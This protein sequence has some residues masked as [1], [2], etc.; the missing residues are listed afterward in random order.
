[1]Q[2]ILH[3]RFSLSH[4]RRAIKRSV[5]RCC[6]LLLGP[7]WVA[8]S[9]LAWVLI[10][11][12]FLPLLFILFFNHTMTERAKE[13]DSRLRAL[14]YNARA[15][16]KAQKERDFFLREFGG[17]DESFLANYIETEVLLSRDIQLLKKISNNEEYAEYKP[18]NERIAFLTGESNK[19]IFHQTTEK[20]GD[21]YKEKLWQLRRPV[22]MNCED[23]KKILGRV[24]GVKIDKY[25]PNPLRPLL[26]ITKFDLS[27]KPQDNHNKVFSVDMEILQRGC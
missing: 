19:M 2:P 10:G 7:T 1:M 20:R 21:F 5:Q 4:I 24:E 6:N 17:A 27:L 9:Y 12:C 13:L 23:V 8:R 14:E 18:I 22:E 16:A 25:L 15:V 3:S 11:I 26:V